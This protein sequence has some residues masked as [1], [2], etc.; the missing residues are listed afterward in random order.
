M[1]DAANDVCA[2]RGIFIPGVTYVTS[3]QFQN[4]YQILLKKAIPVLTLR[5]DLR[6][7]I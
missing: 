7:K 2:Q 5:I 1:L 3:F 4:S 6:L